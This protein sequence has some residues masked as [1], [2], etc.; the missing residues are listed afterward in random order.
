MVLGPGPAMADSPPQTETS[1]LLD[2]PVELRLSIL[3][4]VLNNADSI[5]VSTTFQPEDSNNT[6]EIQIYM[7][8]V[9]PSSGIRTIA[10]TK[11]WLET[12]GLE[13]ARLIRHLVVC[14]SATSNMIASMIERA[15]TRWLDEDRGGVLDVALIGGEVENERCMLDGRLEAVLLHYK[16][17]IT[18]KVSGMAISVDRLL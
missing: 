15:R 18:S 11:E 4:S 6:F 12:I 17:E 13:Q 16:M 5:I 9:S 14:T 2:L 8:I 1:P 3:E 7:R 10:R